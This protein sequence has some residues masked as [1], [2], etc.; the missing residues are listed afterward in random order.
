MSSARTSIRTRWTAAAAAMLALSPV[1][2]ARAPDQAASATVGKYSSACDSAQ[3]KTAGFVLEPS[4]AT[5]ARAEAERVEKAIR[6]LRSGSMPPPGAPR[7]DPAAYRSLRGFLESELDRAAASEPNPGK[8]PL[9]RRL[10]R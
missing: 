3:L 4:H 7:P 10:T 2:H 1:L 8:L 9:L 5:G 6:K